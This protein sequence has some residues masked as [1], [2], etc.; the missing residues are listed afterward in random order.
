[1][2]YTLANIYSSFLEDAHKATINDVHKFG[3]LTRIF[4]GKQSDVE[5]LL[6]AF[7]ERIKAELETLSREG[8][9]SAEVKVL[10]EWM[11][12]QTDT[13]KDDPQIKYALIAVQR[14]LLLLIRYLDNKD[15]AYLAERFESAFPRQERFPSH[16]ELLKK[17]KAQSKGATSD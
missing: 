6:P 10:A 13:Q 9:S 11:L 4:T 7:D 5:R 1:M 15:A 17:L 14:H 2:N 3:A 8:T 12:S 16:I